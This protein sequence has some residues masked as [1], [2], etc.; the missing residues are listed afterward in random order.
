[1]KQIK[2]KIRDLQNNFTYVFGKKTFLGRGEAII[3]D[4]PEH[5][6]LGDQAIAFAE[7]QF[8]VNHVSVRDV[9]HL[10]ESKTISEIKSIKKKYWKK[11][12]SFFSWGRKFR[13][14]LSKV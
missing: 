5:G 14:T 7:N 11:R 12:I 3:I 4:E 1:M 6:N 8:L 10:I 2:S 13:D 9:E